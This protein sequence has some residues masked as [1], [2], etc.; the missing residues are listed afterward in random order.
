MAIYP[1]PADNIYPDLLGTT[2]SPGVVE[3]A[4]HIGASLRCFEGHF[5]GSPI[6][7]GVAQISWAVHFA[8]ELLGLDAPV[9][10]VERLKF[11]HV[12]QPDQQLRL[13]LEYKPEKNALQF[14]FDRDATLAAEGAT[15]FSQGWLIYEA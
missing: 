4:L 15:L 8:R 5:P 9:K 2:T 12:I 6:A 11:T 13:R 1:S 10:S 3:A 14:C 7:P